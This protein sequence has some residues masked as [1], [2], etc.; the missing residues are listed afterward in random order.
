MGALCRRGFAHYSR[1]SILEILLL[2]KPSTLEIPSSLETKKIVAIFK[3]FFPSSFRNLNLIKNGQKSA[4]RPQVRANILKDLDS[5]ILNQHDIACKYHVS[6]ATITRIK[7]IREKQSLNAELI[8]TTKNLKRSNREKVSGLSDLLYTWF[9]RARSLKINISYNI[10]KRK[11]L[12]IAKGL[13]NYD[14]KGSNGFID[15]WLNRYN[16]AL[17]VIDGEAKTYNEAYLE[18]WKAT[19]LPTLLSEYSLNDIY[20][21]DETALFYKQLPNKTYEQ[22]GVAAALNTF[23]V[24]TFCLQI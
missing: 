10:L 20:N 19:I 21:A 18:E 24:K 4:I 8:E 13:G 16:I 23:L 6:T 12:E 11:S 15:K 22:R 14:F 9:L 7:Q 3:C 1:P 17:K 5:D 2:L